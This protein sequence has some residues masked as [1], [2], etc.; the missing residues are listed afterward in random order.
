MF[1]LKWL[2]AVQLTL[3]FHL[4][5]TPYYEIGCILEGTSCKVEDHS[6]ETV[7]N[8]NFQFKKKRSIIFI[9]KYYSIIFYTPFSAISQTKNIMKTIYSQKNIP[10][11]IKIKS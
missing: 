6:M 9:V 11:Y 10:G 5:K 8:G 1:S 4:C 3:Y 2:A 7:R